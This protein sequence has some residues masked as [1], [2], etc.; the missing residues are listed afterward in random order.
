MISYNSEYYVRSKYFFIIKHKAL[1]VYKNNKT[2]FFPVNKIILRQKV[3][4]TK[5][6]FVTQVNMYRD[7]YMMSGF[8]ER[9]ID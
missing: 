1:T 6:F 9:K 8:S 3:E 7:V 5:R 4:E 2:F